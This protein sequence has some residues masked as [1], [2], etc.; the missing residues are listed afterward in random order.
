MLHQA[1][2]GHM[3]TRRAKI[4]SSEWIHKCIPCPMPVLEYNKHTFGIESFEHLVQYFSTHYESVRWYRSVFY[5]WLDI[6]ARNSFILHKELCREKQ[7]E[8]M[9]L[10]AF[11][12]ELTAQLCSIM[13]TSPAA[14]AEH[15][16]IPVV[17]SDQTE[18][19]KKASYGRKTC[20]L[21]RQT[22]K[23]HLSTPWKCKECNLALCLIP[24]RNCFDA[25]HS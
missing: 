17:I 11:L 14:R 3:V 20:I 9:T 15:G 25:W 23:V 18:S 5:H 13:I 2:T 1:H 12:E 7:E 24:D 21:C 4:K 10:R 8:P 6:A 19:S 16:H 22:R